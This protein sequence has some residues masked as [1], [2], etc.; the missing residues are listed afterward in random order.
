MFLFLFTCSLWAQQGGGTYSLQIGSTNDEQAA[1]NQVAALRAAGHT[2]YYVKAEIPGK[3]TWYR[4]RVGRFASAGDAQ[5]YGRTVRGAGAFVAGFEGASGT[6]NSKVPSLPPESKEPKPPK[7]TGAAKPETAK[8]NDKPAISKPEGTKTT[9]KNP[10]PKPE[11]TKPAEKTTAVK[12]ETGKPPEKNVTSKPA[13]PVKPEPATTS[14]NPT[15]SNKPEPGKPSDKIVASKPESPPGKT[16]PTTISGNSAKSTSGSSAKGDKPPASLPVVGDSA[17]GGAKPESAKPKSGETSAKTGLPAKSKNGASKGQPETAGT[18]PEL[19]A[20]NS[21]PPAFLPIPG[22]A[23]AAP[24]PKPKPVVLKALP[25]FPLGLNYSLMQPVDLNLPSMEP[26]GW[27]RQGTPIPADLNT[28][29]FVDQF[30][31]WAGGVQGTL[32]ATTDGGKRWNLQES[33]TRSLVN[34]LFFVDARHGWALV[35]GTVGTQRHDLREEQ[36]LLRTDDGGQTWHHVAE[37]DALCLYFVNREIGYAAGNYGAVLR[38]ENGGKSWTRC[39][40]PEKAL[41]KAV[42]LPDLVFSFTKLRFLSAQIGYAVGNFYG[43]GVTRPGGL[44][45]TEDGG[46]TWEKQSLPLGEGNAEL[47]N[48]QFS[49]K[50]HGLVV[51]ETYRGDGRFVSVFRTDDGG[52]TWA[53]QKTPLM[54]YFQTAFVDGK[55]GWTTGLTLP[56]PNSPENES[57]I[58]RTRDGGLT[59]TVETSF[60]GA[61]LYDIFFLDANHGWAVGEGGTIYSFRK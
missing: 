31:G 41:G 4:I 29:Y 58:W 60:L 51:A 42:K 7:P 56:G 9:E 10:V 55:Q 14:G 3:G 45:V 13:T 18:K 57:A 11:S 24:P 12:P 32:L 2:A 46:Q 1:K 37:I 52:A 21:K 49:D 15:K 40:S 59:W 33:G 54:G 26:A 48:L 25:L 17:P 5:R 43:D 53:E 35:G 38:T 44:F 30:H 19:V 20:K 39:A 22:V 34:E 16:E 6:P 61:R 23:E 8:S 47:T 27:W 28:I 50:A 36:S